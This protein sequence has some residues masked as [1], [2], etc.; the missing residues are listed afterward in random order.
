MR[1]QPTAG[2]SERAWR[3]GVTAWA[4]I[5]VVIVVGAAGWLLGRISGALT[6]FV[7]AAIIVLLLRGP[8]HYFEARGV[9][10]GLSVAI[11]YLIGFAVLGV[12]GAFVL[13]AIAREVAEFLADFPQYYHSAQDFWL[14]LQDRVSGMVFPGWA[15][16][17]LEDVGQSITSQFA[18]WSKSL[19]TGILTAGG[20]AAEFVFNLVFS[21]V[22]AFWVL[23][24]MTMMRAEIVDMLGEHRRAE[25]EMIFSTVLRVL[26]GYIR[27]QALVSLVTGT[28]TMIGLAVLGVPYA[29]V[30]GL[31][32]G[33]LN[34]IPY[35]GAV[36]GGL[37]SAIVA[38]FVGPWTVVGAIV[39]T[40]VAQQ[41]TDLFVTPRVMSQQVDLHPLLVIFSLLVGGTLFGFAGLLFAI[42]LA[43]IGKGLFVYYWEK[44]T[45]R[46]LGSEQGVLFRTARA[47]DE[48]E[49]PSDEPDRDASAQPVET[50]AEE[51][52]EERD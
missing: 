4:I 37:I 22:I 18:E 28:L 20:A 17:A 36:L 21:L 1:D 2:A 46:Q 38:A 9:N 44:H 6:P 25:T 34:V 30:L 14:Q 19:A 13:P 40:I 49:S 10:R 45:Q 31:I 41:V 33:L 23:K 12:L 7:M 48:C 39:W 51:S 35:V 11:S 8:V 26:G 29:F 32:T 43:A 16:T 52:A 24:D 3:V 27:G 15:E 42:P 50:S 47:S 5:G